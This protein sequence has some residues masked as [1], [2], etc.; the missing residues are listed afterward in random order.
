MMSSSDDVVITAEEAL[1][2]PSVSS[3]HLMTSTA[4]RLK[5]FTTSTTTS[6][7]PPDHHQRGQFGE[8]IVPSQ[9]AAI[10]GATEYC[11]PCTTPITAN[12]NPPPDINGGEA[13]YRPSPPLTANATR[14]SRRCRIIYSPRI[15]SPRGMIATERT[16]AAA[17]QSSCGTPAADAART[18]PPRGASSLPNPDQ[19]RAHG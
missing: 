12:D 3:H 7:N 11:V 8:F 10:L 5:P 16:T 9:P 15:N 13:S 18:E 17:S 14:A 6:E 4:K 1:F 19:G 2:V